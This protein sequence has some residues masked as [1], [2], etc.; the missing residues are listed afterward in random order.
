MILPQ[1]PTDCRLN[2]RAARLTGARVRLALSAPCHPGIATVIE[3]AGLRFSERLDQ[4]GMLELKLPVFER[5]ARIDITL[6]D[7][8]RARVTAFLADLGA[9][10]R[11]AV[12][13]ADLKVTLPG[14]APAVQSHEAAILSDTGYI[15]LLGDPALGPTVSV[16][17]LP[18]GVTPRFAALSVLNAPCGIPIAAARLS[19]GHLD[20]TQ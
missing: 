16:F 13:D 19:G 17:T 12:A 11:G 4:T 14:G 3:H 10:S 7:G 5:R 2:V 18:Q 6:A 20:R 15:T 1:R 9:L 8:T